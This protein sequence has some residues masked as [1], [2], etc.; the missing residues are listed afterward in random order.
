M[1]RA[2]LH[3]LAAVLLLGG[4]GRSADAIMPAERSVS[5]SRQFIVYGPDTRLRGAVCELAE[6]SKRTALGV[7]GAR[8][9]WQT[10]IVVDAQPP[11]LS[12]PTARVARLRVNQTGA[13][14][15]FQL[16]LRIPSD[17]RAP[18]VKRELLR[19]VLLEIMYRSQP[20]IPPGTAYVEPPDWLLDGILA[21]GGD[22]DAA[23]IAR[24]LSAAQAGDVLT[25]QKF[26]QQKRNLL[27]SPSRALHRAYSAALVSLL[28]ESPAGRARLLQYI[29][30]LDRSSND[31]FADLATHFPALGTDSERIEKLWRGSVAR[32]A[33]SEPYQ[34]L[35]CDETNRR[36]S[37]IL[38]V[39]VP[40][41]DEMKV[42]TLEEAAQFRRNPAAV[43][44]LRRLEGELILLSGRAHPL[45]ASIVG[46]YQHVVAQLLRRKAPKARRLA[47][48]RATREDLTRRMSDITDYLNWY[49]ATQSRVASGT[50]REYLRA[51]QE[52]TE[53]VP[54]RHD[55]ISVYLDAL[56][57]QF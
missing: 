6:Q 21:L 47:E 40:E 39:T 23:A 32:L 14:L 16:E 3:F 37:E 30:D 2:R 15:K 42:Y 31:P 12:D 38:R 25:L 57:T 29:S 1:N 35:T 26:L 22:E 52:A 20:N 50:F 41:S 34:S 7:M 17:V 9:E 28:I 13:G 33:R 10:P 8:D 18:E 56:E 55:P 46:E 11:D 45:Y 27:D 4:W 5:S 51:A 19:A 24:L 53:P 36:L 49:E 44:D 54:R 48:L 43:P